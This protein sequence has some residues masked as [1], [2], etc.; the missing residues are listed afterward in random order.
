MLAGKGNGALR[1]GR[2]LRLPGTPHNQLLAAL[3]NMFGFSIP[4]FGDPMFPGVLPGLG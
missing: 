4:G 3:V 2:S 1:A